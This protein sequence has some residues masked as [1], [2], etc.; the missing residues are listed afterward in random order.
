MSTNEVTVYNADEDFQYMRKSDII[1]PRL[2]LQQ[3]LSPGV[4]DSTYKPG[5]MVIQDE[6]RVVIPF[7]KKGLITPIMFWMNWIEWNPDRDAPKDKKIIDSSFDP[8]SELCKRAERFDEVQTP[9]GPKMAVTEYY[10]WVVAINGTPEAPVYNWDDLAMLNFSR[11]SHRRGKEWLN[12]M[13]KL[14]GPDG[15]RA[16]MF[17]HQFEVC[18]QFKDEGPKKKYM[19]PSVDKMIETPAEHHAHLM[20]MA[21]TL[22]SQRQQ[23]MERELEREKSDDAAAVKTAEVAKDAN[24]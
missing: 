9:D 19:V 14:K 8:Q 24:I 7:G 3:F 10:N 5:D 18:A 15:N 2:V 17:S 6:K 16:P 1:T 23:I 12:R 21:T 4:T 13:W 20:N 22:R 11:S